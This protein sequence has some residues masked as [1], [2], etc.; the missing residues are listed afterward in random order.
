[1]NEV[2]FFDLTFR[3][4]ARAEERF[5]ALARKTFPRQRFSALVPKTFPQENFSGHGAENISFAARFRYT[6]NIRN[7]SFLYGRAGRISF[8]SSKE[9]KNFHLE[10]PRLKDF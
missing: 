10:R 6:I 3:L 2:N 7:V 1:M 4:G 5:L 9:A 8:S